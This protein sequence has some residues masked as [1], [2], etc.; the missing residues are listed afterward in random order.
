LKNVDLVDVDR[1]ISVHDLALNWIFATNLLKV[2]AIR[3]PHSKSKK[4]TNPSTFAGF[5]VDRRLRF[6]GENI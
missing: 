2:K 4:S 1:K 5:S 3:N 6:F